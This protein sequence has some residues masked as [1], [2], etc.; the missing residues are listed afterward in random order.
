VK[1]DVKE[2]AKIRGREKLQKMVA[3]REI[4]WT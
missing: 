1:D 2:D 3:G 4:I